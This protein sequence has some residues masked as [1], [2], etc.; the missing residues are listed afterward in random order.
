MKSGIYGAL[1]R[2]VGVVEGRP[3][4]DFLLGMAARKRRN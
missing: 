3:S 4:K 1:F 2:V